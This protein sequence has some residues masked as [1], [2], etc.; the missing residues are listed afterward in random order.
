MTNINVGQLWRI[1]KN[2]NGS[3]HIIRSANAVH[4]SP[5][6]HS[7]NRMFAEVAHSC[8]GGKGRAEFRNCV[9]EKMKGKHAE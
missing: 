5:K 6:V 9:A 8:K 3:G 7:I 1:A 2:P 4:R